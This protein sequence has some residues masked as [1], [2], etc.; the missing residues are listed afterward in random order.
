MTIYA[1]LGH[2]MRIKRSLAEIAAQILW[3]QIAREERDEAEG[4]PLVSLKD[5][6]RPVATAVM[7]KVSLVQVGNQL[8]RSLFSSDKSPPTANDN[9]RKPTVAHD[10]AQQCRVQSFPFSTLTS[11]TVT[12]Y[13][14]VDSGNCSLLKRQANSIKHIHTCA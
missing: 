6:G 10:G 1:L 3:T 9:N 5:T 2:V 13:S 12:I 4:E 11:E 7:A 8:R 14:S